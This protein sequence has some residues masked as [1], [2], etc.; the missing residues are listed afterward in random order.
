VRWYVIVDLIC[1]SLMTSDAEHFFICLF[2]MD[3]WKKENV[4]YIHLI[5]CNIHLILFSYKKRMQFSHLWKHE[6]NWRSLSCEKIETQKEKFHL[7]H[8]C[9]ESKKK[10]KTSLFF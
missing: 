7:T 2:A 10:K 9:V 6:R 4:I 3:E 1:I 5:L 8:S